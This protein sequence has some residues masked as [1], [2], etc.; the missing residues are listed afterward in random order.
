MTIIATAIPTILIQDVVTLTGYTVTAATVGSE[1]IAEFTID[2]NGNVYSK[3]NAAARIQQNTA[4]DW[5]R[6]ASSGPGL[7]QCRYTSLTGDALVFSTATQNTWWTL[8]TGD[9]VV[10]QSDNTTKIGGTSSTF[11]LEIR[12]GTGS[13][14]ASTFHGLVA[15]RDDF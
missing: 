12:L 4:N 3:I 14:L 15:D 7:F 10:R 13:T 9:F 5:V 6:P 1:A 2:Q 11:L 8:S